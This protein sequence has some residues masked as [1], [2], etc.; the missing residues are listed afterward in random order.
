M[1]KITFSMLLAG[2]SLSSVSH[3]VFANDLVKFESG[4][5][6][7]ASD[8]N[9]NFDTINQKANSNTT[10]VTG[11]TEKV[12]TLESG[13]QDLTNKVVELD[14]TA[15]IA[16]SA[17]ETANNANVTATT[18]SLSAADAL[19]IVNGMGSEVTN[20]I[21]LATTANTTASSALTEAQSVKAFATEA[22][23]AAATALTEAQGAKALATEA[24][25]TASSA[26]TEAQSVKALATEANTAA[27]TALTEAQSV[28][29]LATEANTAAATAL[30]EAQSVK[31]LATE[32]NTAA[33]TALTETQSVKTLATEANTAATTALTEAQSV[34]ALADTANNNA[35]QASSDA[36]NALSTAQSATSIAEQADL[37]ASSAVSGLSSLQS[38]VNEIDA[39]DPLANLTDEQIAVIAAK[40][41]QKPAESII[42]MNI[43]CTNDASLLEQAYIDHSNYRTITFNILGE[44]S[45]DFSR[46]GMPQVH[47]QSIFINGPDSGATLNPNSDTQKLFLMGG[48]G[49]GLY[50]DNLTINVGDSYTGVLYSRNSQ[51][52]INNTI[53]N[54][55]STGILV[56]AS[57]QV[58]LSTVTINDVKSSALFAR[59]GAQ[60]RMFGD[61]AFNSNDIG[62][63]G[64]G[65]AN[66]RN[67]A[68]SLV[69]NAPT[70]FNIALGTTIN[71]QWRTITANGDIQMHQNASMLVGDFNV[72]G[73]VN[74]RHSKL[75]VEG[76]YNF[77]G[78][79]SL[80]AATLE[81]NGA[82]VISRDLTEGSVVMNI[83]EDSLVEIGGWINENGV[84]ITGDI[85][86][87]K[88]KMSISQTT[89]AGSLNAYN[90]NYELNFVTLDSTAQSNWFGYNSTLVIRDSVL[91][92]GEFTLESSSALDFARSTA[93]NS[94][95]SIYGNSSAQFDTG[96]VSTVNA[97]SGSNARLSDLHV[98]GNEATNWGFS[99]LN[100]D[101]MSTLNINNVVFDQALEFNIYNAVGDISGSSDL[102]GSELNCGGIGNIDAENGIQNVVANFNTAEFSGCPL[103]PIQ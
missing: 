27:A 52:S 94:V 12:V 86:I 21:T 26:L 81:A 61:I 29:A 79:I 28:K 59:S 23:T 90:G 70:A 83:H 41:S 3:N 17:I 54:G 99:G 62:I 20:A 78:E 96:T 103:F 7:I 18:A 64:I 87:N 36:S 1:N 38:L 37:S 84:S 14:A 47:H 68:N 8:V 42:E 65:G 16:Q 74:L 93:D 33:T 48:F 22:N 56:Q 9:A 53:I 5:K 44:C 95:F 34:K 73:K 19:N 11:L 32:A 31:T 55:G 88:S 100:A 76:S 30:T 4:K 45:A 75:F 77:N 39:R 97:S 67:Q 49:G 40:I 6:A 43:D 51:G 63:G 46:E 35:T 15:V 101:T 72:T 82:G 98:T 71:S 10:S 80:D 25:T 13:L 2:F 102:N 24:N 57:S 58:Y 85:S 69:I 50:L 89:M 91:T 66:V 60:I 92:G